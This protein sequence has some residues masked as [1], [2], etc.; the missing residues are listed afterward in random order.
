MSEALNKAQEQQLYA[1]LDAIMQDNIVLRRSFGGDIPNSYVLTK[2][3]NRVVKERPELKEAAVLMILYPALKWMM[4][5]QDLDVMMQNCENVHDDE[6]CDVEAISRL[7]RIQ[8]WLAPNIEEESLHFRKRK[9]YFESCQMLL[10]AIE[11]SRLELLYE[12]DYCSSMREVF[13]CFL[14]PAVLPKNGR[15]K[16][17]KYCERC[18]ESVYNTAGSVIKEY[19]KILMTSSDV[20]GVEEASL[21]HNVPLLLTEYTRILYRASRSKDPAMKL[22]GSSSYEDLSKIKVS[23]KNRSDAYLIVEYVKLIRGAVEIMKQFPLGQ[24]YYD[25]ILAMIE[26][27]KYNWTDEQI[28]GHLGVTAGTFSTR[29]GHAIGV[30][31]CLLFGCDANGL[32]NCLIDARV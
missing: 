8:S 12:V 20:D 15:I 24:R 4:Q 30:F 19:Y 14:N 31:G 6:M 22:L 25:V 23:D 7:R 5:A 13:D 28:A 26:G 27:K 9:E 18:I 29:K 1:L 32:L 10:D 2:C 3:V 16:I 11:E 21:Y 17:M